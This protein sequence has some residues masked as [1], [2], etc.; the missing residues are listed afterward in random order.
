MLIGVLFGLLGF[1]GPVLAGFG[2]FWAAGKARGKNARR[3]LNFA[4]WGSWLFMLTW[5]SAFGPLPIALLN[6]FILLTP[7]V[8]CLLLAANSLLKEM[9]AQR[10]GEY[11]DAA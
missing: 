2:L 1:L 3:A 11:T 5:L 10:V 9:R 6:W 8:V 4:A 7:S